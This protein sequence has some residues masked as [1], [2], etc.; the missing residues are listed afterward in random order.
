MSE[1]A[2]D[3]T[4][5]QAWRTAELIHCELEVHIAHC[6]LCLPGRWHCPDAHLLE[7]SYRVWLGRMQ[8]IGRR[9]VEKR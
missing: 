2:K 7:E 4:S 3:V 1:E 5:E 9:E 8:A 6:R